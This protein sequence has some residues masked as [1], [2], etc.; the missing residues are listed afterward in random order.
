VIYTPQSE[1]VQAILPRSGDELYDMLMQKI[2]PELTTAQLPILKEKYKNEN[3]Q[4]AR[5]RAKRYS[6]A[7]QE[8]YEQLE[9]YR[10]EWT[11]D[12][13]AHRREAMASIEEDDHIQEEDKLDDLEASITSS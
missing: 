13:K 6:K 2:E 8:Y 1:A 12:L 3:A 7:F 5:S 9:A 10:Q 4:E 11:I